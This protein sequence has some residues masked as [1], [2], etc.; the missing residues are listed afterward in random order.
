MWVRPYLAGPDNRG[1]ETMLQTQ[2]T[3]VAVAPG[4][5]GEWCSRKP[6]AA[7]TYQSCAQGTAELKTA[8]GEVF[9]EMEE[10]GKARK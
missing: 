1:R 5:E 8:L 9:T 2:P 10:I 6:P 3:Q 4:N 7:T